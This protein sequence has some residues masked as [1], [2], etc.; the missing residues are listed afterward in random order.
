MDKT[1]HPQLRPILGGTKNGTRPERYSYWRTGYGG[2]VPEGLEFWAEQA[3]EYH[4]DKPFFA[5]YPEY[6][7]LNQFYFHLEGDAQLSSADQS[8]RL[9]P[10]DLIIIPRQTEYV[11]Q[12]EQAKAGVRL[13]WFGVAGEFRLATRYAD[14][15]R[16]SL[17]LNRP[18]EAVFTQIREAL[19]LDRPGSSLRAVSRIYELFSLIE[20][21]QSPVAN[22]A[23]Y[24]DTVRVALS[25]LQEHYHAPFLAAEVAQICGVTA[26]HLRSLFQKW[27][28]ESPHQSHTRYRI[29]QAER[30][31]LEQNL[32]VAEVAHQVGYS[33]PYY[34][35]RVFKKQTGYRPS[36]YKHVLAPKRP[37]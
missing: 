6:S 31:L 1:F 28:G 37:E 20:L 7:D 14:V 26:P 25:Y 12:T 34:F 30:L 8:C 16:I 29:E 2:Y 13:H 23:S 17:G 32:T 9:E 4:T 3:G 24:P 10:G 33:D 15:T 18:V 22:R 36:Q 5:S 11:Y 21:A 19:I 35:S 27:V